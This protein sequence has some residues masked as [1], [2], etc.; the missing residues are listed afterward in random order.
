MLSMPPATI[1]AACPSASRSGDHRRLH[2]RAAHLV[3]RGGGHLLAEA[4]RR[5]R[6]P[7]RRLAPGRRAARSPSPPRRPSAATPP[8]DRARRGSPSPP[9]SGAALRAPTARPESRPSASAR[10]ADDSNPSGS[11]STRAATAFDAASKTAAPRCRA[12]FFPGGVC[13][14]RIPVRMTICPRAGSDG[15]C[16]GVSPAT[17]PINGMTTGTG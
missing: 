12:A 9:S 6:L 16:C 4:R 3:E 5:A 7:R 1:D 10:P 8:C 11:R 17:W 13:R 15:H 14:P 2:A